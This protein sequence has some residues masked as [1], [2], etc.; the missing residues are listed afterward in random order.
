M[1]DTVRRRVRSWPGVS[2][3]APP[4]TVAQRLADA[5]EVLTGLAL[6]GSDARRALDRV[7]A[8]GGPADGE[9]PTDALLAAIDAVAQQ[10]RITADAGR[11]A[12]REPRL[13]WLG[14]T[15]EHWDAYL[16]WLADQLEAHARLARR[17]PGDAH[18]RVEQALRRA[19]ADC[20]AARLG[21][22]TA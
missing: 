18:A 16:A 17:T 20:G 6:V 10:A 9:V 8:L 13:G 11:Q 2:R 7:A 14:G 1:I 5:G 3:P 19:R 4:D 12:R 15:A 21:W 22:A